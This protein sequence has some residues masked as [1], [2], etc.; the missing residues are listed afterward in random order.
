MVSFTTSAPKSSGLT[1]AKVPFFAFP[2]GVRAPATMTLLSFIPIS[3]LLLHR[4]SRSNFG[5]VCPLGA[6][7]ACVVVILVLHIRLKKASLSKSSKYCSST[8]VPKGLC[9]L[10][11]HT[12]TFWQ[13]S[14]HDQI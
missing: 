3:S 10:Q 11:S 2:T 13:S 14:Y 4:F 5:V 1:F 12:L 6:Y 7:V 9:H 8:S